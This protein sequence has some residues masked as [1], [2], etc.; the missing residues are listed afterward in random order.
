LRRKIIKENPDKFEKKDASSQNADKY[1]G[2]KYIIS[3]VPVLGSSGSGGSGGAGTN[4]PACQMNSKIK[5]EVRQI[6]Y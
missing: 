3:Y 4:E 6:S 2:L 5:E 1:D